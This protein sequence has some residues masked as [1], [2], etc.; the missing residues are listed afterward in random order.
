M[1]IDLDILV[2]TIEDYEDV[3]NTLDDIKERIQKTVSTLSDNGWSG[4]AQKKYSE[5]VK[6]FIEKDYRCLEDNLKCIKETLSDV[7]KIQG[8][9]LKARCEDFVSCF[10][11]MDVGGY[12][13]GGG[14]ATGLLSLEYNNSGKISEEVMEIA[15]KATSQKRAIL[16]DL[17][18]TI[19]GGL[20]SSGLK[21]SSLSIEN[22]IAE[23][24]N[25]ISKE[26]R[27]LNSFLDSFMQYHVGLN[28]MEESICSNLSK[29]NELK[30]T[31]DKK[32]DTIGKSLNIG[33]KEKAISVFKSI[34][35]D[36]FGGGMMV[37]QGIPATIA[38]YIAIPETGGASLIGA[39]IETAAVISGANSVANG[40][41]DF[42]HELKGEWN[43]VGETNY[44]KDSLTDLTNKEVGEGALLI[45]DG[46]GTIKGIV[47]TGDTL[48]KHS[49][50]A[51]NVGKD[52]IVLPKKIIKGELGG[53]SSELKY[54]MTSYATLIKR[55]EFPVIDIK[56]AQLSFGAY[57][58]SSDIYNV[59]NEYYSG[60]TI[61]DDSIPVIENLLGNNN[62]INNNTI[63][64]WLEKS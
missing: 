59:A 56:P 12:P 29:V 32:L 24:F 62:T 58:V 13:E 23:S 49:K 42:I 52:A 28:N 64:A 5:L 43:E 8:G 33:F 10:S 1:K 55:R 38:S 61:L 63:S 31:V 3:M 11:G 27:R 41:D 21:F 6:W 20:F 16:D 17:S 48:L 9:T 14:G 40:I 57:R 4:E 39:T 44:L 7:A 34:G 60:K 22:E 35:I 26:E 37:I 50:E 15:N 53:I 51:L 45:V 46:F 2:E 36:I 54:P 18:K 25:E 19:N 30:T 47:S